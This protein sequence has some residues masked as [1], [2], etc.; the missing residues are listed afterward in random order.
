VKVI[1]MK[2]GFF[3]KQHGAWAMLILPFLFGM[4]AAGPV[5]LH[6][7]LFLGWLCAYLFSFPLLQWLRTGKKQRYQ[8]PTFLYGG[9]LIVIGAALLFIRPELFQWAPL[10]IPM[11]LVNLF[12]A[13]RNQERALLNDLAAVVQ[14]SLMVFV[15]FDA[16]GG[17]DWRLATE[18]FVF[19]LLYFTGTVLFVKTMIREK[20]NQRYYW[21]SVGY[22][23]VLPI[24][25][26][27]A[28]DPGL[29][30][31]LVLLLI[32]AVWTPRTGIPV[33][34]MGM[35]EIA[36]AVLVAVSVLVVVTT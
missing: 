3:P 31:V 12:Y 8:T 22:H 27:L 13:R 19:S 10:F 15:A 34:R 7:L 9:L 30:P 1:A 33:K 18:L 21:L 17:E 16:G 23:A 25:V 4:F 2:Q 5:P 29:V 35:L 24:A 14:F 28:V 11:L 20:K 32:R 36:Y 6:G 26:G